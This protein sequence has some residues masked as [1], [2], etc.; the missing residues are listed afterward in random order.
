VSTWP[1]IRQPTVDDGRRVHAF[2]AS[3]PPLDPNSPYCNLLQCTHFA[4]TCALAETADGMLVGWVGGYRVPSLPEALFVWQI[5]VA[6]SMRGRNLGPALVLDVLGR[7]A[8]RDVRYVHATVTEANDSSRRMFARLAARLDA[9]LEREPFF[10]GATHL[11]D[12]AATEHLLRIGPFGALREA[13]LEV[14]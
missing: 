12:P 3:S 5:A 2:I 4:E 6:P 11:G 13:K 8:C 9:P 10:D 7:A 14:G 1:S